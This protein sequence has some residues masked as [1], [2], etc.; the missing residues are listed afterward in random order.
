MA[1]SR[2][3]ASLAPIQGDADIFRRFPRAMPW[4]GLLRPFRPDG[5][6][7]VVGIYTSLPRVRPLPACPA[8]PKDWTARKKMENGSDPCRLVPAGESDCPAI[9]AEFR[10]PA[11][12]AGRGPESMLSADV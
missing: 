12:R 3:I 2:L 5:W 7:P 8:G 1:R 10:S 6:Q 9:A 4:A 11:G